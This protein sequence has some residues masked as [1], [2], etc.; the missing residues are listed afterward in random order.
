MCVSHYSPVIDISHNMFN[1]GKGKIN[2]RCIVP[3]LTKYNYLII[4]LRFDYYNILPSFG[5]IVSLTYRKAVLSPCFSRV[6]CLFKK[7]NWHY[8]KTKKLSCKLSCTPLV[9]KEGE[10]QLRSETALVGEVK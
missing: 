5:L 8:P 9:E 6:E 7:A 4:F 10:N 1:T 2:M 3:N